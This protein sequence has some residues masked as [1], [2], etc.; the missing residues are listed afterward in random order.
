MINWLIDVY[1]IHKILKFVK[2]DK[3]KENLTIEEIE[4]AI[5]SR[6]IGADCISISLVINEEISNMKSKSKR[7]RKSS[8]KYIKWLKSEMRSYADYCSFNPLIGDITNR[9]FEILLENKK[10]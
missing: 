8:K 4:K 7:N 10:N 2:D 3:I 9:Y 1:N 5:E 6:T